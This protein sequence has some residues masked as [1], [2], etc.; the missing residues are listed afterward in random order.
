MPNPLA[1]SKSISRLLISTPSQFIGEYADDAVMISHAWDTE[2]AHYSLGRT[3]GPYNRRYFIVSLA[4]DS[5]EKKSILIT[6]R[7]DAEYTGE[8]VCI[9]LSV[10]FGKC[11]EMHGAL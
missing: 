5:D 3:E 9:L 7:P 11:F 1:A 2:N 8:V 10:L 4:H 6:T